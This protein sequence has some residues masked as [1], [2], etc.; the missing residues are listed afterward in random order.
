MRGSHDASWQ[1]LSPHAAVTYAGWFGCLAEPMRVRLLH[2]VAIAGRA[3]TVGELTEQLEI[4]QS[5][6]SHHVRKLAEVGLVQVRRKGTATLVSVD[7]SC[8]TDM[9]NV[10]DLVMGLLAPQRFADPS[11]GIVVRRLESGDWGAVRRIY[12]E[13]IA[14]RRPPS[15]RRSRA[16]GPSSTRGCPITG[17]SPRSTGRSPAGR[18]PRPPRRGR[19]TRASS[20]R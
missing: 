3:V 6:C 1:Q 2:A 16:G 13:G 12:A 17:G 10:A 4:S 8:C 18:P 15:R 19:S 5:T 11:P 7:V 14:P 9:P 20:R